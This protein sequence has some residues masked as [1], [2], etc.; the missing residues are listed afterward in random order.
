[1]QKKGEIVMYLEI[2]F[3][4]ESIREFIFGFKFRFKNVLAVISVKLW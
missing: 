4:S 3:I 1:M 2:L